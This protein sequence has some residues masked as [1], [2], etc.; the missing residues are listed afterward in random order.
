MNN[1]LGFFHLLNLDLFYCIDFI[2]VDNIDDILSLLLI[3]GFSYLE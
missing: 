1:F 3:F 2:F